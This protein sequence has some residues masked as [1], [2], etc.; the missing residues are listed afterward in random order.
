MSLASAVLALRWIVGAAVVW[1]TVRT[2][3]IAMIDLWRIM[4][5]TI[6]AIAMIASAILLVLILVVI[7]LVLLV[8]ATLTTI[9][10]EV[11]ASMLLIAV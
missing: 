6:V 9:Y 1:L 2:G 11:I 3:L 4:V 8:V 7:D 5:T 10:A